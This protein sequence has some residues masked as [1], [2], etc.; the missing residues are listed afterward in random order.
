MTS[1]NK[2]PFKNISLHFVEA[3]LP[4]RPLSI[5]GA[6]LVQGSRPA[7]L[8][9]I[10]PDF[11]GGAPR[12]RRPPPNALP[13]PVREVRP[14]I[15]E[16]EGDELP[17]HSSSNFDAEVNKLGISALTSAAR[18]AAAE[19]QE[20]ERRATLAAALQARAADQIR[21][22]PAEAP[23]RPLAAARP[24]PQAAPRPVQR[25]VIRQEIDDEEDQQLRQ[26]ARKA[27]PQVPQQQFRPAPAP[28]PKPQ[29][30]ED[31]DAVRRK[32]PQVQ[33]LRKYRTDNEDGSISWGFENDDGTFKEE[34]LGTDCMTRGKYGYVDPD[35]VRREYTYETGNKCDPEDEDPEEE[36][37]IQ[38]KRPQNIGKPQPQ[39]RPPSGGQY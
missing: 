39:F 19:D 17:P 18:Q 25:P 1:E 12:P 13:V 9:R 21:E 16:E 29:F 31:D 26:P 22:R 6:V 37:V 30:E 34:T 5:P 35:G 28:R 14:V 7:P 27:R 11:G 33:I 36:P 20:G 15:E 4:P 24:V 10:S 23:P 3:Q 2:C 8:R 38:P 32:K